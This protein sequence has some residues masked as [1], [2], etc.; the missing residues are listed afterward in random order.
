MADKKQKILF[1]MQLPPPV[2]GVSVMNSLIKNSALINFELE[3]DYINLT[4]AKNI[5]DLQK[6]GLRK[7]FITL[8]IV[9]KSIYKM[10]TKRYDYVYI[11]IFPFGFAFLKDSIIVLLAKAFGLKP[12]LHLH[13]YGFKKNSEK[14]ARL[15]KFYR[16]VFRNTEVICLSEKLI[17]DVEFIYTGK[18]Y[19]LPNGIPQV[20]F[21][22][23]Y[24][25]DTQ[26]LSLLYLSNLIKGKGILVLIDALEILKKKKYSFNL[27]VVGPEGD[28]TYGL[29]AKLA[30]EK[31]LESSIE[32]IGPK[33]NLEKYLE[34]KL[35]DI[36][37]L[38]SD[39]DT[40]G[41]VFLEAMQF[42]VPC[43]GT[44]VGGIP[45]VLGKGNGVMISSI[46][47]E[48][49]AKAIEFLILN[50]DER[51]KISDS[52]FNHYQ[53]NFTTPVFE[54]RLKNILSGNPE[55]V[56]EQLVKKKLR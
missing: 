33:F 22:N 8:A 39:Y 35:A 48:D 7:Y 54:R 10:L 2:H 26:S 24:T 44:E 42:G 17:E 56:N 21:K 28:I 45:D 36:F 43:I 4:T 18:I 5:D 51:K 19:I 29:L 20:N 46:T 1:V 53:T 55:L 38:P 15:K 31:D 52:G 9:F 13:T 14:S 16:W 11:T 23:T 6:S 32:L 12:L 27:R 30:K 34:F 49:L 37:I 40:F 25:V 41:L 3:C 47:A 50:P